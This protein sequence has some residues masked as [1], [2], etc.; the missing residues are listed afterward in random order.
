MGTMTSRADWTGR[1]ID[2]KFRLIQWLGGS[3]HS[4][5]FLT[6]L[7]EADAPKAAIKLMLADA[8]GA[9]AH[10]DTWT[11]AHALF[12]P[13]LLRLFDSGRCEV[14]NVPML[15]AVTGLAEESLSLVLAERPLTEAEARETLD[16]LLEA[17]AY[18]HG[19]GFVHG[20]LKPANI[21]AVEDRLCISTESLHL[22]GQ[23]GR[24][25]PSPG[26]YDAPEAA[27]RPLAPTADI[28]SLGIILVE[29][30]SQKRPVW[31]PILKVSL[32]QEAI[33]NSIPEPF[34]RI[35]RLCLQSNPRRRATIAEIKEILNP[36][37][38]VMAA[39]PAGEAEPP[40][41]GRSRWLRMAPAVALLVA[42]VAG[43]AFFFLRDYK[44]R[45]VSQEPSPAMEPSAPSVPKPSP[46][47]ARH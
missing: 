23:S 5:V 31:G 44:H 46:S 35:A 9:K 45:P 25:L 3:M 13:N 38:P 39:L 32:M 15:Y 8:M 30:L 40:Q 4:S 43:G 19:K 34:L 14:D 7:P 33:P 26:P 37:E 12:H 10:M 36:P 24:H 17:L 29:A 20:H 18:L 16:Q 22:A 21:M 6:E 41:Q 11:A 42:L 28:W 1:V 47:V 27:T 2:G